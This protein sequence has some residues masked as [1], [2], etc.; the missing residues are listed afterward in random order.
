MRGAEFG[1]WDAGF[2]VRGAGYST[3]TASGWMD[4]GLFLTDARMLLRIE[5][6]SWSYSCSAFNGASQPEEGTRKGVSDTLLCSVSRK[7]VTLERFVRGASIVPVDRESKRERESGREVAG[8]F[9]S[10][11]TLLLLGIQLRVKS[12]RSC[13]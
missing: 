7:L 8:V 12:L 4:R 2:G 10:R 6:V 13:P 5:R 11:G 9:T 1:E 3:G